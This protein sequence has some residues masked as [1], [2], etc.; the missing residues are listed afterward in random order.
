MKSA[1]RTKDQ[2]I[3]LLGGIIL[4]VL[5]LSA[6]IPQPCPALRGALIGCPNTLQSKVL[7]PAEK[8][9][10][11]VPHQD[12]NTQS[13][14]FFVD[15]NDQRQYTAVRFE[16][17]LNNSK[18]YGFL[19]LR[20][21]NG[22]YENV[23]LFT[24]PLLQNL[25]WPS[26]SASAYRLYQRSDTYPD[27]DSFLKNLPSAAQ[28]AADSVMVSRYQLQKGHY[29]SLEPLTSLNGIN[30]VLTS[31]EPP[32][33]DGDWQQFERTYDLSSASVDQNNKISMAIYLPLHDTT[34]QPFRI[35]TIHLDYNQ[36]IRPQ[37]AGNLP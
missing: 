31:F 13:T 9:I 19:Q 8:E 37:S 6:W 24:H 18:E 21:T 11:R 26:L 36:S 22:T 29:T 16:Y 12:I 2:I 1:P 10:A 23:S 34:S 35:G 17:M 30:Y 27:F 4:V 20:T 32:K 28:L 5:I 3:T 33:N 14:L 7:T 15:S 25:S